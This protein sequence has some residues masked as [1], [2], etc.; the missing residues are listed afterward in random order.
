MSDIKFVPNALNLLANLYEERSALYGDNYKLF[1]KIMVLLFQNEG[2]TLKTEEDFNR[3]GTFAQVVA[4]ISRY[5]NQFKV[6][7]H[8]DSLDDMAVYAMMLRELD[9]EIKQPLSEA[10][11]KEDDDDFFGP[12]QWKGRE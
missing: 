11:K 8:P 12:I 7:G 4:K 2:L 10:P 1:G 9:A 5:A 6:G 3:F